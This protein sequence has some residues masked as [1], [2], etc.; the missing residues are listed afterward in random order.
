MFGTFLSLQLLLIYILRA[1]FILTSIGVLVVRAI[2]QLRKAFIPYGKTYNGSRK[3]NSILQRLSDITV[4]KAWFWHYYFISVT[5]S[6]FWGAQFLACSNARK[7]CVLEWLS[8]ANGT[9]FLVW[10]MMLV[11]GCRR[12]YE[13]LF[14]QKLSSARMWIGHYLVGCAFY[15]MMSLSVLVEGYKPSEGRFRS[16][17]TN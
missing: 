9:T 2:P 16:D 3:A 5:L 10:G 13:S 4:P 6:V 17:F 15:I 8:Y 14:M 11:Q 12:L 7:L 1:Y